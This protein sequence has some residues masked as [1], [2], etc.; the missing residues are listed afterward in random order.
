MKTKQLLT[1]FIIF[2]T[3]FSA[4]AQFNSVSIHLGGMSIQGEAASF[5]WSNPY[6]LSNLGLDA[7]FSFI[8]TFRD[9]QWKFVVEGNYQTGQH[10]RNWNTTGTPILLGSRF[11]STSVLAGGRYVLNPK[12][13]RYNYYEGQFLP[14]IGLALGASSTT[15]EVSGDQDFMQGFDIL[16]ATELAPVGEIQ[17][18]ADL[19]LYDNI[20][21]FAM[22]AMRLTTSDYLDGIRGTTGKGDILVRAC[23]GVVYD[24][25]N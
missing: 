25:Q 7:G 23:V 6:D 16:M 13:N 18:G 5:D 8:K 15:A 24:F 14:F 11:R 12:V 1:A 17:M 2:L 20:R 9:E 22:G 19:I 10:V 3:F 4:R 21:L